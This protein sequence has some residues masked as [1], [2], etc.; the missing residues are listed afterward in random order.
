MVKVEIFCELPSLLSIASIA[1]MIEAEGGR[2]LTARQSIESQR[3]KSL[4]SI[5]SKEV[6]NVGSSSK[7]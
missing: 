3:E 7:V 2:V 1:S 4:D 5:N 6:G